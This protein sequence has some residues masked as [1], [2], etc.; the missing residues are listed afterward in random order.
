MM[1]FTKEEVRM[2]LDVGYHPGFM[3]DIKNGN[4]VDEVWAFVDGCVEL[5]YEINNSQEIKILTEEGSKIVSEGDWIIKDAQ[6]IFYPRKADIFEATYE[7]V[8]DTQVISDREI[9]WVK[10]WTK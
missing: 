4:N 5:F 7:R 3:L 2:L 9:D 10:Y 1:D 6:G 8:K